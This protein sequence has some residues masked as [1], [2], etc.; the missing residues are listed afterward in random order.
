M[1]YRSDV[2][3]IAGKN[4]A[5]ELL[6][7]N[8]KYSLMTFTEG[9]NDEWLFEA[10]YLK[11]YDDYEEVQAY[12]DVVNKYAALDGKDDGICFLR[13]GEDD[14]D[15]EYISNGVC[16]G[17]VSTGI[18][19]NGFTPNSPKDTVPPKGKRFI[20]RTVTYKAL[21][22]KKVIYEIPSK[23]NIKAADAYIKKHGVE[24]IT[25]DYV[26]DEKIE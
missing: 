11:W 9:E 14:S 20:E 1:G 16:D 17:Y 2:K 8:A 25:A 10:D 22:T 13:Q 18:D 23:I 21:V 3:I 24:P 15:A 4:A 19:V 6:E 5:K 12:M 26:S 7:V